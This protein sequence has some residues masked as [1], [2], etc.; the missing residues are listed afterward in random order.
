MTSQQT[1]LS[2]FASIAE[3]N[4]YRYGVVLRGESQWQDTLVVSHLTDLAVA[5]TYQTSIFQLG[6][7]QLANSECVNFK[8]GQRFLGRECQRLICDL[9]DGFD[10]NSFSSA[11][12]SLV[13]GGVLIVLVADESKNTLAEQ[14][15]SC[16]LTQLHLIEQYGEL[17]A[18]PSVLSQNFQT[19]SE[20]LDPF[21]QQ[22][23]AIELI[24]KVLLGHRK[25][26]LVLTADR[27]RG[28]SSA[29]G[30]AASHLM[31]ERDINIVVTAPNAQAVA[32]VFEHASKRLHG[33][34]F[35]TKH[36]L[37]AQASSLRYIAPDELL[38]QNNECDLLF[39]DEAAAIPLPMLK[40]IVERYHRVVFS[41][42]VHGYEGSGRGFGLKFKAWLNDVRPGWKACHLEQPIRWGIGDPLEQWLFDAFLLNVEL[43][44]SLALHSTE[45][46]EDQK[47]EQMSWVAL[48]KHQLVTQ[49]LANHDALLAAHLKDKTLSNGPSLNRVDP[50][51]DCFALLVNA[52]YQTTPNDFVQFLADDSIHLF[53]LFDNQQCV[54]CIMVVEEG[55]LAKELIADI[56]HGKRRPK[57]HLIPTT[58][59][60]HL[61]VAKAAEQRCLRIM[62]I[63][64]HPAMQG[65]GIGSFMLD[66]LL[67]T[68]LKFDYLA[69]SF[70]ATSELVSF[71]MGSGYVPLHI[72]HNRDQASGCHSLLMVQPKLPVVGEW[73][74][75][76]KQLF[77]QGLSYLL[78][79]SLSRLETEM[80]RALLPTLI[81][82]PK[83][84]YSE[85]YLLD[86]Y[87]AGGASFDGIA[88]IA[89]KLMLSLSKSHPSSNGD[90]LVRK[91]IQK[92][93][94]AQCCEQLGFSGRKQVEVVL[95]NQ[96]Q[97]LLDLHCK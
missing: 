48:D 10:A 56:Q 4:N 27:G 89:T 30:I 96:L 33:S 52:H 57:G 51:R 42:T 81:V 63:A 97:Q 66:Q 13:G 77:A 35:I 29:L 9:R 91:I 62:R 18:L 92:Q 26:P 59:A 38:N 43:M 49:S 84:T 41:T 15:L 93:S 11:L 67:A 50:L 8:K 45:V 82:D 21:A 20:T 95:R 70:G 73:L 2:T 58:L 80:V 6:G 71:W 53:A 31:G 85:Q 47:I 40:Q 3:K 46:K 36:Q 64:V 94:W 1:F 39:V 74:H 72:G 65:R 60:N 22:T 34:T 17:P 44:P 19:H 90:L 24:K 69:T 37:Q 86:C 76:S 7:S 61:G 83:I 16:C 25:R 79:D 78:S 5:N 28:K 14:W 88:F 23:H 87:I 75:E 12:G 68:Q 32:P 54:G 55:G